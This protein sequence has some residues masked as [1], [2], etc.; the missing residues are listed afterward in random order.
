MR[1]LVRG[2]LIAGSFSMVL[3]AVVHGEK[4]SQNAIAAARLSTS[5]GER[6]VLLTR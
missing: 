1:S 4:R 2:S 5:D 3:C 6:L